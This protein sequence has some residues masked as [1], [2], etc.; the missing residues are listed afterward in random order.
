MLSSAANSVSADIAMRTQITV[1]L[2][3][4]GKP[5]DQPSQLSFTCFGWTGLPGKKK[6]EPY[7]PEKI[8][9]YTAKCADFGC[10]LVTTTHFNYKH[11]DYCDLEVK[12]DYKTYALPKYGNHPFGKCPRTEDLTFDNVCELKLDIP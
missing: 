5:L 6:P 4:S 9:E 1:S 8:F 2:T 7:K 11:F 10:K 3:K 12:T